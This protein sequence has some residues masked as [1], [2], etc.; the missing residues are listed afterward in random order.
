MNVV[1]INILLNKNKGIVLCIDENKIVCAEFKESR[2][3]IYETDF[4]GSY[5]TLLCSWPCSEVEF[6]DTKILVQDNIIFAIVQQANEI[7]IRKLTKDGQGL[8]YEKKYNIKGNILD[9][10]TMICINE[11][12]IIIFLKEVLTCEYDGFMCDLLEDKNYYIYDRAIVDSLKEN[13]KIYT[14]GGQKYIMF[15]EIYMKYHEK[16]EVYTAVKNKEVVIGDCFESIGIIR[17]QDFIE[18]I[19][20]EQPNIPLKILERVSIN[21]WVRY[22]GMNQ[23][24]I[25]YRIKNFDTKIEKIYSVDKLRLRK[26]LVIEINHK[27]N[28]HNTKYIYMPK[29]IQVLKVIDNI[30][31]KGMLNSSI[32]SSYDCK[33]G[34]VVECI[35]DKVIVYENVLEKI[36]TINNIKTN[37]ISTFNGNY[38]SFSQ[39]TLFINSRN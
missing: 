20:K 35:E 29:N 16:K 7:I 17:V 3:H 21:G 25:Y 33:M 13:F 27:K 5:E 23:S 1:D 2:Y 28:G 37:Q 31:L 38:C 4:K 18:A 11:N 14:A 30:H 10:D 9:K 12:T 19:K 24:H 15:E 36:I 34:D 6:K 32:H 26:K 22:L 8:V 39:N